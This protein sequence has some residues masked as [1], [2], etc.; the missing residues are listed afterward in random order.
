MQAME[1]VAE[2]LEMSPAEVL[3]TATFYEEYWLKPKGEYLLQVCRSLSCELC[4]SRKLTDHLIRKLN[5]EEGETTADGRFTLIELECLGA[6]GTAPVML[7]NDV[8]HENLTVRAGGR[9]DRHIA[10]ERPRLSRSR[11]DVGKWR[12]SLNVSDRFHLAGHNHANVGTARGAPG[13]VLSAMAFG[14]FGGLRCGGSGGVE[15]ARP[16]RSSGI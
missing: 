16:M 8:L 10:K 1:E 2:F 15:A 11:R 13:A 6:C 4:D 9:A 14:I 3:D 7:I 12:R 5:V